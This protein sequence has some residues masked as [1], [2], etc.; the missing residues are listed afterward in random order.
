MKELLHALRSILA[1]AEIEGQVNADQHALV[2]AHIHSL[3]DLSLR[4]D[5]IKHITS[6]LADHVAIPHDTAAGALAKVTVML[7][8]YGSKPD[9]MLAVIHD[10]GWPDV[11]LADVEAVRKSILEQ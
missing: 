11:T 5:A 6:M 10:K 9:A 3:E 4:N 2:T 1:V 8:M 7:T